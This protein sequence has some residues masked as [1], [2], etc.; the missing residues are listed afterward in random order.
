MTRKPWKKSEGRHEWGGWVVEDGVIGGPPV[1]LLNPSETELMALLMAAKGRSVTYETIATALAPGKPY[2]K[3]IATIRTLAKNIR[4]KIG[5]E[6]VATVN[7]RAY[8]LL[9]KTWKTPVVDEL[10]AHLSAALTAARNLKSQLEEGRS[11][12]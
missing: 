11:P 3:A 1:I 10:I 12:K 4:K 9:P 6:S 5:K 2:A 8:K 7:R